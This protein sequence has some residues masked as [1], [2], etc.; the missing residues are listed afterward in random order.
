MGIGSVRFASEYS[1]RQDPDISRRPGV[2]IHPGE[3]KPATANVE[4]EGEAWIRYRDRYRR[5]RVR[6][7]RVQVHCRLPKAE[8]RKRQRVILVMSNGR[9]RFC[10][11]SWDEHC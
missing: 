10:R 4:E 3:F 1:Q 6:H 2:Y 11:S 7:G 5:A 9:C 8:R